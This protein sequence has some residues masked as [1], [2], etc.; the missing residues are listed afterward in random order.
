MVL[1]QTK[2]LF[3]IHA[4]CCMDPKTHLVP[5]HFP[6]IS[7]VRRGLAVGGCPESVLFFRLL[8][9]RAK[10][11]TPGKQSSPRPSCHVGLEERLGHS[12]TSHICTTFQYVLEF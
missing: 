9:D 1:R 2:H 5:N 11:G 8:V 4:I 3:H 12:L 6:I 10:N 7:K